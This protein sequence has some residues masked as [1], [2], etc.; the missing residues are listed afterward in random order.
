MLHANSIIGRIPLSLRQSL[1][2]AGYVPRNARWQTLHGGRVS[3]V[4][5]I[6]ATGSA[7]SGAPHGLVCKLTHPT[8]SSPLFPVDPVLE[9]RAMTALGPRFSV[10]PRTLIAWGQASCLLYPYVPETE[11]DLRSGDVGSVLRALHDTRLRPNVVRARRPV[12]AASL[13]HLGLGY[14]QDAG[15]S[16]QRLARIEAALRVPTHGNVLLHGDPVRANLLSTRSGPRLIDWQCIGRGDPCL[17]LF[18]ALSPAMHRIYGG[19]AS[20]LE[21]RAVLSGYGSTETAQ[22]YRDLAPALH[23]QMIGHCLWRAQRGDVDYLEAL[24]VEQAQLA[25][26]L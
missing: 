13:V 21:P 1:V 19:G 12:F 2:R 23:V 18:L 22:R 7:R 5:L 20:P 16:E 6:S 24:E 26:L 3:R 4:F 9:A 11:T 25:R 15:W 10:T 14:L 17:D 8:C